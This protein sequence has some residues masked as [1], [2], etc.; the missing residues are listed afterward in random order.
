M[1]DRTTE[2]RRRRADALRR[3]LGLVLAPLVFAGL[4]A[5]PLGLEA[6]AH[7]LAAIVALAVVLWVTEAIPL[8]VTAL[9]APA[10]A[11]LMGVSPASQALAPIASPLIF[12]FLGGFF[13]ARALSIQ[14]MDR[15]AALWILSRPRLAGSPSRA[16][17]AIAFVSFVGSMWISNTATTA[18][19]LPVAI[20]LIAAIDRFVPR[21]QEEIHEKIR[22]FG[23]G[24]VL[25]I[26][27]ASSL[28]GLATPI[29][30]APNVITLDLLERQAGI[31]LDFFEWMSF[32]LPVGLV[33]LVGLLVWIQARFPPPLKKIEGLTAAVEGQLRELGPLRPG[34]L[35]ALVVFAFAVVGWLLPSI[36]KLALGADD[37]RTAWAATSLDEGVVAILAATILFVTPDGGGEGKA[38]LPWDEAVKIDWGTLYLLGGGLALGKMMFDTGLAAALARGALDLAGP[39][40]S[41]PFGLLALATFLMTY[42]TEIASNTATTSMM[43]PVLLAIAHEL[44]ID[45]LPMALCVTLAASNAFMLPVSTPPNAIVYGSGHIRL[46]E[47]IRTGFLLDVF[48]FLVLLACGALLLPLLGL[49]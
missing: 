2:D 1:S 37:P 15:R 34:E 14:G 7:R 27:Y 20:G 29:G 26:A 4:L 12:L 23:S 25:A 31:R 43:I 18:M 38:V 41:S 5:A 13:I 42:L 11:V 28:G 40:A 3:R 22:R 35:R 39:I 48:G 45:P 30:T 16:L 19:L 6:P 44:G 33:C 21:D 10:L 32:A 36:L 8:A 49:G 46:G 9:F 24:M 47:M 17:V